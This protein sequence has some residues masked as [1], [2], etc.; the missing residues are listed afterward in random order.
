[1]PCICLCNTWAWPRCMLCRSCAVSWVG[2]LVDTLQRGVAVA[3]DRAAELA[4]SSAATR[5]GANT[6]TSGG[7]AAGGWAGRGMQLGLGRG[8]YRAALM[9]MQQ[10]VP[11]HETGV[12][13]QHSYTT[14]S[15]TSND[16]PFVP[17][18]VQDPAMQVEVL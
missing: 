11:T 14:G 18:H 15:R 17:G 13:P 6:N 1:M 16:A 5:L 4:C 8:S 3:G 10:H 7:Q 12:V 2:V 9:H